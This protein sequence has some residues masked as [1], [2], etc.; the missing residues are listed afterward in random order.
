MFP[1]KKQLNRNS[2]PPPTRPSGDFHPAFAIAIS[3][4]ATEFDAFLYDF[5][6]GPRCSSK[7]RDSETGLDY[8]GARYM[9]SAQGRFTSVDEPLVDQNRSDPQSWN[10]FSYVRNNPLRFTDPDGQFCQA[11]QQQGDNG[12][13][14][15]PPPPPSPATLFLVYVGLP[16]LTSLHQTNQQVF[17]PVIDYLSKPRDTGCMASSMAAGSGVGMTGG[18]LVGLA[19]GPFAEITVPAGSAGG[20]LGGGAVGGIRGLTSCMSSSGPSSGGEQDAS[21]PQRP[22]GVPK[23]WKKVPDTK[24]KGGFKYQDPNNPNYNYVRV[25]ADGTITQVQNGKSFDINGNL[26]DFNSSAAHGITPDK[27]VFRP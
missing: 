20:A 7:E 21:D 12:Q 25:R 4:T 5:R 6:V 18:A 9:S 23:N 8:F 26:V 11:G 10:L 2:Q 14:V 19:G 22:N 15:S 27:F 3:N 17:Q 1:A 13:C 24:G 16:V